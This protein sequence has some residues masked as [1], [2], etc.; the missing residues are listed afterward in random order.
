M[1]SPIVAK[2]RNGSV[3]AGNTFHA[4]ADSNQPPSLAVSDVHQAL[5]D[6]SAGLAFLRDAEVTDVLCYHRDGTGGHDYLMLSIR[7][8]QGAIVLARAERV[9]STQERGIIGIVLKGSAAWD[10]IKFSYYP[11]AIRGPGDIPIMMLRCHNVKFVHCTQ[12]FSIIH[13]HSQEYHA[14]SF[15]C[16]W[17]AAALVLC[18]I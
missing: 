12:L 3:M 2:P 10:N 6:E 11:S 7:L 4:M 8:G 18:V 13:G 5:I 9:P 15:N 14:K 17:F 1:S 16:W